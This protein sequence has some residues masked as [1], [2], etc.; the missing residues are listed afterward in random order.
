MFLLVPFST[1]PTR[2]PSKKKQIRIHQKRK[3]LWVKT[4]LV[5]FW[6]FR[7]TT[8]VRTYFSGWIGT[9]TGGTIW[10]LTHGHMAV[11]PSSL[12]VPCFCFPIFC[13]SSG[14]VSLSSP[15]LFQAIRF[16]SVFAFDSWP[17]ESLAHFPVIFPPSP[18]ENGE[19]LAW[20]A[21]VKSQL[22]KDR[23]EKQPTGFAVQCA[24]P[25]FLCICCLVGFYIL[26]FEKQTNRAGVQ[27]FPSSVAPSKFPQLRADE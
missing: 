23:S 18:G 5:P 13:W 12:P 6:G 11:A 19:E 9:F 16:L 4:V 15:R 10:L 27:L 14:W 8:H 21:E 26:N 17:S 3:W 1:T 20:A 24:P 25:F 22:V 7:C 2:V